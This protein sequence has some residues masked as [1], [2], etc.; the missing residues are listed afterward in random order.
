MYGKPKEGRETT[1]IIG[2][3]NKLNAHYVL[4]Y[5]RLVWHFFGSGKKTWLVSSIE[6][7]IE[8]VPTNN[9]HDNHAPKS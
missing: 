7:G 8:S 9:A 6:L 4:E 5:S 2:S 1:F 3:I